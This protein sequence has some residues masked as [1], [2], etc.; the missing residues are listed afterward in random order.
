V[1]AILATG[2]AVLA[3]AM[4][5]G[6]LG[7]SPLSQDAAEQKL[8]ATQLVGIWACSGTGNGRPVSAAVRW[9]HLE[10]GSLWMTL[11]PAPTA[12]PTYLEQWVWEDEQGTMGHGDWRTK[13]DPKSFD[14]ASFTSETT[15]FKNG[16]MAWVR[17]AAQS[18]MSRTFSRLGADHLGFLESY[19]DPKAP[20]VVYNLD[21]KRT[22]KREP[23]PQ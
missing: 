12:H 11:H 22:L 19:G 21:C 20:Q 18:T 14:Q 10:D 1:R 16:T 2:L 9:Y 3:T 15:G 7:A 5:G 23:P 6:L 13:P 17:H 8:G 4:L